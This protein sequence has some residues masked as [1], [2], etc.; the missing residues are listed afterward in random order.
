MIEPRQLDVL[1]IVP[2]VYRDERGFLEAYHA[3][4]FQA[5]GLPSTCPEGFGRKYETSVGSRRVQFAL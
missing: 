2:K 3:D 1:V 5:L 4:Q